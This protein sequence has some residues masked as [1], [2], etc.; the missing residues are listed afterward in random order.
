MNPKLINLDL[1][2]R[3]LE[4]SGVEPYG[5]VRSLRLSAE[6]AGPAR[7]EPPFTWNSFNLRLL[8]AYLSFN[9]SNDETDPHPDRLGNNTAEIQTPLR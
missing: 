8:F 9:A 5:G 1:L 6:M 7:S 3:D 2:P 4:L